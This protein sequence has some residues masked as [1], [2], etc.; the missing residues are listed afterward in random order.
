M[1]GQHDI[2]SNWIQRI[3]DKACPA[4]EQAV[5]PRIVPRVNWE[6]GE[7]DEFALGRL[8]GQLLQLAQEHDFDGYVLE[9]SG[10]A[11]TIQWVQHLAVALHNRTSPWTNEP[12]VLIMVL[13]PGSPSEHGGWNPPL[14]AEIYKELSKYIH[15]FLVMTYD[16]SSSR[17]LPGPNAPI[18]WMEVVS[19]SLVGTNPHPSY[20]KQLLLGIPLYG[21]DAAEPVTGSQFIQLLQEQRPVVHLHQQAKEHY[22]RYDDE[23]GS[24]YV[25]YP[26]LYFLHKRLQLASKLN[27]GVALWE[28]GQGL[29]YMYDLF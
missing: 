25:Y 9:L 11:R 1:T 4:K 27:L 5:C 20:A 13:P 19:R 17:G 14:P 26:T 7:I 15:R 16:F 18:D 6:A 21:R 23:G 24:H 8:T 29:N 3:R 28:L 22:F 10:S 2:D 12:K